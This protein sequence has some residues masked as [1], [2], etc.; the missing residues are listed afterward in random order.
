MSEEEHQKGSQ[1]TPESSTYPGLAAVEEAMTR[2]AREGWQ[3]LS[4]RYKRA[5]DRGL[6]ISHVSLKQIG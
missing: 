4:R 1:E 3:L 5:D 2:D 6:A